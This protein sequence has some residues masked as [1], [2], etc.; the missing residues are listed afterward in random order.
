MAEQT[1]SPMAAGAPLA[2]AII[3]GALI[4]AVYGQPSLGL[5]IGLGIGIVGAIALWLVDR[6]RIGR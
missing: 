3:A 1:P 6:G 5:V 2:I 4:G